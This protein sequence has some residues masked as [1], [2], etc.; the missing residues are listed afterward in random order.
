MMMRIWET[1]TSDTVATTPS[2][3]QGRLAL[4]VCMKVEFDLGPSERKRPPGD[5]FE[6]QLIG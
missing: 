3:H 4:A 5:L 6:Y 1:R 2:E